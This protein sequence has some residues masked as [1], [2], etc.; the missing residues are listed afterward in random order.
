MIS[1]AKDGAASMEGEGLVNG[2]LDLSKFH[3]DPSDL[4]NQKHLVSHLN[5]HPVETPSI[6]PAYLPPETGA[7]SS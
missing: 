3:Q 6:P 4:I 1:L 2:Q 5:H 7:L